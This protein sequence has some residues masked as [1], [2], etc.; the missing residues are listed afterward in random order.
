ML[1]RKAFRK[2]IITTLA[3]VVLF[4]SIYFMPIITNEKVLKTDIDLKYIDKMSSSKVYL[5]NDDNLLVRTELTLFD[6]D[7][8]EKTII[9]IIDNLV[10]K[11]NAFIPKG[12]EGIIPKEAKV[13]GVQVDEGIVNVNFSKEI[14]KIDKNLE[15][16]MIEAISFSILELK[17]INGVSIY[18]DGSNISGLL[19]TKIPAIITKEWG[20]N[21]IYELTSKDNIK[22]FVVYYLEEIDD[23]KYYVPI[24]KYV[25]DDREKIKVIIDNL[26]SSYIYQPILVSYLNYNTELINYEIDKDIMVLNFNNSIFMSDGNILEEVVYTIAYSVMDNYDVK[27]VVFKVDNKE[28]IKKEAKELE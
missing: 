26:S 6:N 13:L 16:K 22:K 8:L 11:D 14:L 1:R 18:V 21:K 9:A 2:I 20:I 24:T 12:L 28:I 7:T 19:N 25:N 10:K 3:M 17:G 23:K 5:L 27:E 4:L 15:E